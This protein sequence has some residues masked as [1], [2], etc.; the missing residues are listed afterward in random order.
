[1]GAC[2]QFWFLCREDVEKL[3]TEVKECSKMTGN[4]PVG[5]RWGE[6][7]RGLREKMRPRNGYK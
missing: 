5:W 6:N 7:V 2:N 1:M 4:R 3:E